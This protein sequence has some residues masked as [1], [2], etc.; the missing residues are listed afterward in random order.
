MQLTS[1]SRLL[2]VALLTALPY[3][4]TV[5]A[6]Q[7]V[8]EAIE[9]VRATYQT[10]RQSFVAAN[11][12]LTASEAGA[13]WP[14]YEQYRARTER[15][16]DNLVKLVLEYADAYPTV[17]PARAEAMLKEYTTLEVKLAMVRSSYVKRAGKV[18]P[19]ARALR[20][21]QIENRLDLALRLQLASAVPLV[22][23]TK[24]KS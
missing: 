17:P 21:A 16:G 24:P 19:A 10:D 6:E 15:L 14:L 7:N 23:V 11:L 20:W 9:I 12:E 8:A 2:L 4:V 3:A 18:I 1:S 22:P 13:F 5:R